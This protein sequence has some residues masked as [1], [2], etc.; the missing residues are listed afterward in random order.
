MG[1]KIR[2]GISGWRYEAWRGV[3]YPTDL[4]QR[5]ELDYASRL[6][7]AVELNGSFYSLQTPESYAAWYAQTPAG[8]TFAVKGG[9]FITHMR[10]LREVEEPLANFLASGLFNLRE[11]LGPILWQLPPTFKYDRARLEPFLALLPHDTESACR[12]ARRRSPWMK[13]RVRLGID[14]KRELRH[15]IE[16]R[17]ESFLNPSFVELLR[18]HRIA[19]VVAETAGHWPLHEDLTTDFV[20]VRLH[21]DQE[22]YR[23]GYDDNAL[24]RWAQ[25]IRAWSAGREPRDARKIVGRKSPMTGPRDVYC[26]F[27]NTDAKSRAPFD[28]Q[29]LMQKLGL[30]LPPGPGAPSRSTRRPRPAVSARQV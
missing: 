19:L 11:K 4:P 16:I 9:R 2:I 13:G 26:F 15:A 1:A 27:D 12:L 18:A 7:S 24:A 6:F 20:Y 8:F 3:F 25:R 23:S 5:C 14:A 29:M 17:H 10:K 22:L 21:G 28:A 30:G